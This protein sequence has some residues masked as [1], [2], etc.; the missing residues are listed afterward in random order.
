L[1]KVIS[2]SGTCE[3][4]APDGVIIA[5]LADDVWEAARMA[6]AAKICCSKPSHNHDAIT[7]SDTMPGYIEHA[8]VPISMPA[9]EWR[10][11]ETSLRCQTGLTDDISIMVMA[12]Q[13]EH[14]QCAVGPGRRTPPW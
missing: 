14:E 2:R 5:S 7:P 8:D 10:F 4:A 9:G 3:I 1:L 12:R 11:H 13:G 6:P